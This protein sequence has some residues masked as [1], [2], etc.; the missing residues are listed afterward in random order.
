MRC[1]YWLLGLIWLC[2]GPTPVADV[3]PLGIGSSTSFASGINVPDLRQTLEA[4]LRARRPQEFAFIGRV[5]KMVEDGDLPLK[6]VKETF[7]YARKKRPYPYP[8]FERALIRR[9]AALGIRVK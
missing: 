3:L 1:R 7:N 9:A 8:Y 2:L 6:L 5:V 4:G